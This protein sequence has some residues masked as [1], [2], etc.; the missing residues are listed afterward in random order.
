[1]NKIPAFLLWPKTPARPNYFPLAIILWRFP[2]VLVARITLYAAAL[3]CGLMMLFINP[4]KVSDA[5][6]AVRNIA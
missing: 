5:F 3:I 2:F 6:W 1:M 4:K